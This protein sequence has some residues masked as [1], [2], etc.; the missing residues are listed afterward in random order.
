[1]WLDDLCAN[2]LTTWVILVM[3]YFDNESSVFLSSTLS[4]GNSTNTLNSTGIKD[5]V[6]CILSCD[7]LFKGH[8][9][10]QTERV[11]ANIGE[12]VIIK[13]ALE[14]PNRSSS[15]YVVHWEKKGNKIP[16]YIW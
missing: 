7:F 12:N 13:C 6:K 16:I 8:A 3:I 2:W 14:N 9:H 5:Y 1:M 10:S 11:T 15:S 4:F